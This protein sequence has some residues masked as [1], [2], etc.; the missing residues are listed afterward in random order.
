MY[1]A[2]HHHGIDDCQGPEGEGPDQ[3]AKEAEVW[4]SR[5][6]DGDDNSV[7]RPVDEADGEQAS[8]S[9]VEQ[10]G[11]ISLKSLLK[12]LKE[13]LWAS[14]NNCAVEVQVMLRCGLGSWVRIL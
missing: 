5:C 4:D 7:K 8:R 12:G 10:L 9:S 2:M 3:A 13:G 6:E 1:L 11:R 14:R